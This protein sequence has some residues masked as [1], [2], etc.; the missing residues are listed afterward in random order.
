MNGH[1]PR[2]VIQVIDNLWFSRGTAQENDYKAARAAVAEI[3]AAARDYKWLVEG[4]YGVVEM[5]D[6]KSRLEAALA[7]F[8][9]VA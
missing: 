6:G 7:K 1:T 3:Y 8:G 2:S 9:G 4:A 5:T